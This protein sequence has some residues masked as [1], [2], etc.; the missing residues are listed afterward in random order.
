[1]TGGVGCLLLQPQLI[2]PYRSNFT[3]EKFKNFGWMISSGPMPMAI[4]V[5]VFYFSR[6]Q[7][8]AWF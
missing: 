1:M 8:Y 2:N 3:E 4:V 6:L 7:T 5:F